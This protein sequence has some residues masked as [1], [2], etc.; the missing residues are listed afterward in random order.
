MYRAQDIITKQIVAIKLEAIDEGQGAH[1]EHEYAV[2]T[3]LQDGV[4][5]PQALWFGRE[6]PYRAMAIESLGPSLAELIRASPGGVFRFSH[7]VEIGLQ[8]VSLY[9][10]T[11]LLTLTLAA[12]ITHRYPALSTFTPTTTFIVISNPKTFLWALQNPR[13]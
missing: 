6:G 4:G 3:Q 5:L 13:T 2:L 12:G 1:L 10:V 9:F 11:T 7:V 8:M